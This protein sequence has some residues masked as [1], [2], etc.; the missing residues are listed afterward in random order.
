MLLRTFW[1]LPRKQVASCSPFS[2]Y[3]QP[4]QWATTLKCLSPSN[5][6][7]SFGFRWKRFPFAARLEVAICGESTLSVWEDLTGLPWFTF[8]FIGEPV[9]IIATGSSIHITCSC[10]I[11]SIV[12]RRKLF[13]NPNPVGSFPT[14]QFSL[15][16]TPGLMLGWE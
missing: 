2:L 7:G 4:F 3:V 1:A 8:W 16:S 14:L 10:K 9:G 15:N 6:C 12:I 13:M 5:L 11:I